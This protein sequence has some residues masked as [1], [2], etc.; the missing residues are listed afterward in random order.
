MARRAAEE[1]EG[2]AFEPQRKLGMGYARAARPWI[3]LGM[4]GPAVTTPVGNRLPAGG[5]VGVIHP[6]LRKIIEKSRP[7]DR[8]AS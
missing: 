2:V 4:L 6:E 1:F 8:R 5:V 7:R 3:Y